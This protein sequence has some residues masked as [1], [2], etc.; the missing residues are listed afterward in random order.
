MLDVTPEDAA[1]VATEAAPLAT[2]VFP[3]DATEAAVAVGSSASARGDAA[4]HGW[5]VLAILS[6]L[7][8]FASISTDLYLPAMPAMGEA[9]GAD[10]GT[11]ELTVSGYLI[12]FSLGQLLWGP[13]SDRYGRRLPVAVGLIL[14]VIGSAGCALADSASTLIAARIVQAV[15]ACASVVLARAMVRDLYEGNR[16]AQ[17]LS[18]LI[19][20]MAIAP[21]IGPILGAQILALAGWRAIFWTRVGF[22]LAT[23]A[24]LFTLPE[25]LPAGQRSQESLGRSLMRYGELLRQRRL[26]GYA[27]AGGFFYGGMFAYI[28]GTPFAYITYHHVPAQLYGLLFAVGI[29]GIMITNTVNARLVMRF[30]S[31]RLLVHGSTA[32]AFSGLLLAVAA[33]AG[34]GGLWGLVIPLF[35]FVSATGFIVANSIAGALADFPKRAGAVSALIGAIHYGSGIIGSAL[36]GA[37]A[38]GT[39]RPMGLVI[40]LAGVGS[41]LGALTLLR[42]SAKA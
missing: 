11:V 40:A 14:F 3:G 7:M 15:G 21:L 27:A 37:F 26:L 34:W 10:T 1:V 20:V 33:W 2:D 17:M 16:A 5:R 4:R 22:G 32:A 18:T 35:L 25:T 31:D 12:G 30:G 39:P 42:G 28:A 38:D 6:A 8:G 24:A 36:V 13:I 41:L 29:V 9:L 23:L 19:T